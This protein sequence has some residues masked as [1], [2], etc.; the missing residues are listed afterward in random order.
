MPSRTPRIIPSDVPERPLRI[1]SEFF[2]RAMT[3]G[4][5]AS[6]L[7]RLGA[8]RSSGRR[9][10]TFTAMFSL[11]PATAGRRGYEE[12]FQ[13]GE[14]LDGRPLVDRQHPHDFVM[15]LAAVWRRAITSTTGLTIAGGPAGEPALGPV[16]F[17]HRASAAEYPFATLSHHTFD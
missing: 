8:A 14:A 3:A 6:L 4:T 7:D 9:Q 10:L 2:A 5:V 15:Q 1:R 11:D 17:M 16:A 12:L 13:V